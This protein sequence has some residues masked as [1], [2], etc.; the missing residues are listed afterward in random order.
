VLIS[1]SRLNTPVTPQTNLTSV[2]F[3]FTGEFLVVSPHHFTSD[4]TFSLAHELHFLPAGGPHSTLS[5]PNPCSHGSPLVSINQ[6][7][8]FYLHQPNFR[9]HHVPEENNRH[10]PL[11][12]AAAQCPLLVDVS[13]AGH[14]CPN[15]SRPLNNLQKHSILMC[16]TRTTMTLLPGRKF[17]Q[18]NPL[19]PI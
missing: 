14:G 10:P 4:S 6:F 12:P 3:L 18:G 13:R 7:H 1:R 17:H 19:S 15:N 2:G 11:H 16:L 5:P 8:C 9:C